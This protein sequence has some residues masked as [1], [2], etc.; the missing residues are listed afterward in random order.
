MDRAYRIIFAYTAESGEFE[1]AR[2]LEKFDSVD[3]YERRC[4]VNPYTDRV[5]LEQ[6]VS[7]QRADELLADCPVGPFETAMTLE[8]VVTPFRILEK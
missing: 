1:G 3:Q 2:T 5:V 4:K 6:G 7:Q 8:G